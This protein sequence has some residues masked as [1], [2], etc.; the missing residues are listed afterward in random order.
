MSFLE[1]W[2]GDFS[3]GWN[4]YKVQLEVSFS[5]WPFPSTSGSP[6]QDHSEARWKWLPRGPREPAGL[7]LWLPLPMYFAWLSKLTQLQVRS[8]TASMIKTF[9]FLSDGVCS[10]A[11]HPP[12]SL[13]QFGHSRYLR[14]FLG[15]ARAICFLQRVCGFSRL[16]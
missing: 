8:E 4:C 3:F 7:F 11:A 15:P 5:L 10:E 16:S 13:P 2:P 14:C 9:R 1:F 6:P 12:F